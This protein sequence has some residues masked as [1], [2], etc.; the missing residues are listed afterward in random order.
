[1]NPSP[2][3]VLQMRARARASLYRAA[4][5]TI[6]QALEPL[7]SYAIDSG[8]VERIGAHNAGKIIAIEFEGFVQWSSDDSRQNS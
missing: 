5:F 8:I 3:I 6:E 4:E 2:F 7:C 1:M